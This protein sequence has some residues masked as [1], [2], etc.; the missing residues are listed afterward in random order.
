VASAECGT[1]RRW[2]IATHE[3]H[4][5][6]ASQTGALPCEWWYVEERVLEAELERIFERTWQCVGLIDRLAAPGDYITGQVGRIPVVVVRDLDGRLIAAPRF[7]GATSSIAGSR[8]GPPNATARSSATSD[9]R[10]RMGLR[11]ALPHLR[12]PRSST[13]D[14]AQALQLRQEPQLAL[15]PA[16]HQPTRSERGSFTAEEPTLVTRS[17]ST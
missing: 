14:L 2:E 5:R 4:G 6:V 17:T 12:R 1:A 10:S 15:K 9:P 3:Q 16:A 11:T 13:L 7:K 8:P